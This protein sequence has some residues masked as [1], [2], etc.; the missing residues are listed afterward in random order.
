MLPRPPASGSGSSPGGSAFARVA[1]PSRV[2]GHRRARSAWRGVRS[3]NARRA[4]PSSAPR[5]FQ[6]RPPTGDSI[7]RRIPPM[8]A[9]IPRTRIAPRRDGLS[10]RRARGS[11]PRSNARLVSSPPSWG[12][13]KPRRHAIGQ[14][15]RDGP[16]P[17]LHLH[18]ASTPSN[19]IAGRPPHHPPPFRPRASVLRVNITPHAS[20]P[21]YQ[22][23][24]L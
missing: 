23:L 5:Q 24:D 1:R 21:G 2:R 22:E 9:T 14:G 8:A 4:G 20:G 19:D 6:R 7:R 16:R 18:A 13:G 10:R 15:L 3:V 11:V 17:A 12:R